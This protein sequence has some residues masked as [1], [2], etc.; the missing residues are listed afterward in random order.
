VTTP[1]LA[2]AVSV[3][4]PW[5]WAIARGWKPVENRTRRFPRTLTGV[6]VALHAS[7]TRDEA[8][9]TD[10]AA[11][12][13]TSPATRVLPDPT[14]TQALTDALTDGDPLA[15]GYGAVIAVVTF[16]GSH[17]AAVCGGM[18]CQDGRRLPWRGCSPWA[19]P[20]CWHWTAAVVCPLAEPVPCRGMPG[21]WPL[22]AAA[23]LAIGHQLAAM[24]GE[25]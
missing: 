7:L 22:P 2:R 1:L 8:V 15:H 18:D 23:A 20:G 5:A 17:H 16:T 24:P 11:A 13:F 12:I 9:F 25:P 14:A 6:P 4:Q 19:M 3:R 10:L 21:F